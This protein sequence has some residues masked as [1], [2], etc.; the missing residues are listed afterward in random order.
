MKYCILFFTHAG[1]IKLERALRKK[2]IPCELMPVPR[3]LSSSCGIC[4]VTETKEDFSSFADDEHVESIY[5]IKGSEYFLL[6][7][8]E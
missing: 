3:K 5:E 7:K 4:A 1:A 6:H 8:A 2:N